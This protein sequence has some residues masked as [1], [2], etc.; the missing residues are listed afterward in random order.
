MCDK[1][2]HLHD[3]HK[4]LLLLDKYSQQAWQDIIPKHHPDLD[5]V[6]RHDKCC[7]LCVASFIKL[8]LNYVSCF[9][10]VPALICSSED[11]CAGLCWHCGYSNDMFRRMMAP[12]SSVDPYHTYNSRTELFWSEVFNTQRLEWYH[13]KANSPNKC[14]GPQCILNLSGI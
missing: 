13:M 10:I 1:C 5:T 14:C 11:M 2:C 4:Q 7:G 12:D 9:N 3:D 8:L 6:Y